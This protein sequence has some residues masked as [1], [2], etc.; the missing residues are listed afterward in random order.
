MDG[1]RDETEDGMGIMVPMVVVKE[2]L[3]SFLVV[4]I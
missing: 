2:S 3:D 1:T 4:S